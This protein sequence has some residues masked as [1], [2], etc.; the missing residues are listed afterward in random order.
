MS[1]AKKAT[2]RF[3]V[4]SWTEQVVTDI[5]GEGQER[6]GVR[7]PTRGITR[8]EVSYTYSGAIEGTSTL[9]YLITYRPGGAPVL[10]FEHFEGS[11]DG[12]TGS[13][14][15]RHTG[16]QDETGVFE[17]VEVV[18]G[19]GTGELAELRGE[20]DLAVVGHSEDGYELVLSYQG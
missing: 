6:G 10:G 14:V 13:C 9:T 3:S 11:I 19:L 20:A 16:T 12:R 2:G 15:L 8:A 5:D 17:H 18:P 7:Y 1:F 4:T